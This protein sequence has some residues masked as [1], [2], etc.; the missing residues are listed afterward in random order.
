ML[1]LAQAMCLYTLYFS[2]IELFS[3]CKTVIFLNF[4]DPVWNIE[5][6]AHM[7]AQNFSPSSLPGG[8]ITVYIT[9]LVNNNQV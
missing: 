8:F 3:F 7:R 4:S 6:G 5:N 9:V 2:D 1:L